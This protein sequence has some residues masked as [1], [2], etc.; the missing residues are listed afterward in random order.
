MDIEGAHRQ[1]HMPNSIDHTSSAPLPAS[2]LTFTPLQVPAVHPKSK[3][4]FRCRAKSKSLIIL[5]V[6]QCRLNAHSDELGSDNEI[7]RASNGSNRRSGTNIRRRSEQ[8]RQIG[9]S[10]MVQK[11]R[12]VARSPGAEPRAFRLATAPSRVFTSR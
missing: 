4:K 5:V 8:T 7:T 3:F 10:E 12:N 9:Q 11:E 6:I 2:L 1:R